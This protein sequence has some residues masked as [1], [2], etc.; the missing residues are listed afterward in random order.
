[1]PSLSAGQFATATLHF[2]IVSDSVFGLEGAVLATPDSEVDLNSANDHASDFTAIRSGPGVLQF[3]QVSQDVLETA[4]T[5]RILVNRLGGTAGTVSVSFITED[6]TGSAGMDYV[7]SSGTLDFKDGEMQKALSVPLLRHANPQCAR[8]F[9]VR[10]FNPTSGAVLGSKTNIAVKIFSADVIPQ[11]ITECVSVRYTNSLFAATGYH[12]PPATLSRD[13]RWVLFSST[14]GDLSGNDENGY[15]NVFLRDLALGTTRLISVNSSG[16][17]RGNADSTSGV[18]SGDANHVAF[19]TAATDLTTNFV[20]GAGD[21]FVRDLV[22]GKTI[23]ASTS[24]N[25]I[26][27]GNGGSYL[28]LL[29]GNG[30]IVAFNSPAT[31]LVTNCPCDGREN[32]FARD[33][34]CGITRLVSI[35][36]STAEPANGDSHAADM[37]TDGR[38]VVFWSDASNLVDMD[39]NE[40]VDIFVR[41]LTSSETLLVSVNHTGTGTGNGSSYPQY[42][43]QISS[44][45]RFVLFDSDASDLVAA[46]TN[47]TRDVFVRD[48]VLNK[49]TLVSINRF[50]NASGN[51]YSAGG[52]MTPDGRYVAFA[53]SA[54]DLV[55]DGVRL[56]GNVY[57][58]DMEAGTTVLV[59]ISCGL[60]ESAYCEAPALSDDGRYVAF[61]SDARDLVPGNFT[62]PSWTVPRKNIYRRDL[63]TGTTALLSCNYAFTGT[64]NET[65][66][67]PRISADGKVVLFVSG[68]SDLTIAQDENGPDFFVWRELLPGA[69]AE[70][71]FTSTVHVQSSVMVIRL[72]VTN[73]GPD[74]AT[75]VVLNNTLDPGAKFLTATS[76]LGNCT[77]SGNEVSCTL[78]TLARRDGSVITLVATP[79]ADGIVAHRVALAGNERDPLAAN[80]STIGFAAFALPSAATLSIA[81]CDTQTFV[82]WLSTPADLQLE[83]NSD[84]SISDAWFSVTNG[85]LS[86]GVLSTLITTSDSR[87]ALFFRLRRP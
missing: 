8:Q 53:S 38:Y 33:L 26:T 41:D 4:D 16:L 27:G 75:G 64:G 7:A 74:A 37:S 76:T 54:T 61:Y 6:G 25:R 35:S 11:G 69:N 78:G 2:W 30:L 67:D 52:R 58:R 43:P 24:T 79:T 45:G 13:G 50:G 28:P 15:Y 20:T 31:D 40:Q 34:A 84:L 82:S 63:V 55:S 59:S 19:Q 56:P 5:V 51:G 39:T 1:V 17:D 72:A 81:R 47:E 80:N 70:L 12:L 77:I 87:S 48:L 14:S 22:V 68:A 18:L 23:L 83:F 42:T 66:G 36:Q 73:Y 60:S 21:I 62:F 85:F 32:V 10:L 44:D 86:N 65:S 9:F 46:D 49:T 71:R 57:L 3:A 29:S